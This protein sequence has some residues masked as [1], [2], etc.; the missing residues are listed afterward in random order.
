MKNK[1]I[2]I[3]LSA[4]FTATIL[5]P[6]VSS[7]NVQEKPINTTTCLNTFGTKCA[8]SGEGD[9]V[10]EWAKTPKIDLMDVQG[11]KLMINT[12]FEILHLGDDDYGYIKV[13]TNGGSTWE[14][15]KQIQGYSPT[16]TLLEINL[17][18]WNDEEIII[19]FHYSTKSNSISDGWYI[20]TVSVRGVAEQ[21]Y[22]EDFTGYDIGDNWNDWTIVYQTAVPNAPPERPSIQGPTGGGPNKD[23]EFTFA[24]ID[25]DEDEISYKIDWGDGAET[26]WIGPYSSGHII[27]ETHNWAKKG[28][29][30]IRAKAKD[31]NN[32]ESKWATFQIIIP[33]NKQYFNLLSFK[34][35]ERWLEL[36][37]SSFPIFGRLLNI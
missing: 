30:T 3:L 5:V 26:D 22:F 7:I 20:N 1:I 13:S 21:V 37:L 9:N 28:T 18:Q 6:C 29:Y 19:A 17:D 16:W 32:E 15:A 25:Y 35:L 31:Q 34:L 4:L 12:Q 8:W 2:V 36:I 23:F 10:D 11:P 14:I 27:T 33:K 24:S